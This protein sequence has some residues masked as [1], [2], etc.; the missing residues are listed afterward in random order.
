MPETITTKPYKDVT[1]QFE[2]G[3]H[4]FTANGQKVPSVTSFTGIIDKSRALLGWAEK[5]S[6]AE[7]NRRLRESGTLTEKD[8]LE[9]C[10]IHK[11]KKEQ[12]ATIG[13]EA[14]AWAEAYS[15]GKN[16]PMPQNEAVA[17]AVRGFLQWVD[18][19]KFKIIT[20]ERHIY[21]KKY[22][23]AGIV[24]AEGKRKGKL[25]IIDYK[26]SSGI[27][28]EMLFQTAGYQQALQ[29][30]TGKEYDERWIVRFD[31]VTGEFQPYLAENFEKDIKAFLGCRAIVMRQKEIKLY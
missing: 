15:K 14:H 28:H 3:R 29:E 7:L 5:L 20:S 9:A 18:S 17:N 10:A 1:L 19:E 31:K 12:A 24:D 2:V 6:V 25:A 13:T 4:I 22:G 27:Y 30:M 16:P 23:Y 11:V 26:T 8:I 21:S